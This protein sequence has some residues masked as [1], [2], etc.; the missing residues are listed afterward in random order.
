MLRNLG[1]VRIGE[2]RYDEAQ[3]YFQRARELTEEAKRA[4]DAAGLSIPFP[5][6]DVHLHAVGGSAA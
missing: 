6:S 5:Q 2:K 3:A 4:F 1:D